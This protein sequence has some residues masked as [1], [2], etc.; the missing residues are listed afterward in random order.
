VTAADDA[1]P[2]VL[3]QKPSWLVSEVARVAHR[4][5]TGELATAGSRS[6]RSHLPNA[7]S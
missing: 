4:L 2:A 5:L 3:T 6:L 7:S 1:K